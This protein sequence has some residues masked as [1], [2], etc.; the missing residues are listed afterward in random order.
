MQKKIKEI[1][2]LTAIVIIT[3]IFVQYLK[4]QNIDWAQIS[5][6]TIIFIVSVTLGAFYQHKR[7]SKRDTK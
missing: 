4:D 3:M 1:A 7:Y 2:G 5:M 6:V